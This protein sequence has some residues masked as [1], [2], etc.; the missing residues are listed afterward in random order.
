MSFDRGTFLIV[1][2][3]GTGIACGAGATS[4][5]DGFAPADDKGTPEGGTG[6]GIS[7]G[8]DAGSGHN[9]ATTRG[10][11]AGT[12]ADATSLDTPAVEKQVASLLAQMSPAQKIGQMVMV[13]Y[14][15]LASQEDITTYAL[16]ALLASGGE[17]PGNNTPQDWL[18]LTNEFRAQAASTPLQIPLI[19]GIDAVHG[20][21]K[22][23]GAT[24][25][26][27][28]IGMG[29]TRDSS[30]VTQEEQITAAEVLAMGITMSFSPDS[31]VGQDERWGRTY[32][33]F[34]ETPAL[35]SQM[36][37][38]AVGGY[39]QPSLG[40]A[41]ALLACPKHVL[42]AGGTTWGTGVDGG[43]D[44]GDTEITEAE[45]RSVH[46]PPF[47]A[48]IDAGAMA[49]MV[50]YSSWNGT[51]M[52]ASTEW[53]T[54]VIKT[55]LGFKGFLLSDYNAIGQLPG[56]RQEQE[57]TA[58]NA[59]LD[60]IMMSNPAVSPG[61][62]PPSPV[63]EGFISDIESLVPGTIPQSRIDD[64]VTRI[65]R[66]KVISG[67]FDAPTPDSSALS[68]IGSAAH[69]QVARQAVRESMVLLQNNNSVLP[70]SKSAN[71]FVAGPGADDVGVQS[72]GW[73]LGWQGV[74]NVAPTAGASSGIGGTSILAGLQSASSGVVTYSADGSGIPSSADVIVAVF[75]ENPYAEFLGDTDNPDFTN[76][77]T[78][79]DPSGNIIYDGYAGTVMS[80]LAATSIPRVL[81]LVTGRPVHLQAYLSSFDA[82]VAAWLPGS[83]GE[84][85]ADVLYG[86][87]NFVGKLPKSWPMDNTVLPISSLQTGADPLFTFGFGLA[88]P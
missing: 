51:K 64:A 57:A 83:E 17:A 23:Q 2:A 18:N 47:Q 60:M 20:A 13:D 1:L 32:E 69:R 75:Y 28:G 61:A 14:G 38:A 21:A 59:G 37:T 7:P 72:G 9:D 46:L 4:P 53:L 65:L 82:V 85:V 77:S 48:A 22:V 5:S 73:T 79:Q 30:L 49:L 45:M 16:G 56:T 8:S 26:P 15:S 41:T 63:Y 86:D 54:D 36:V 80:S 66:A 58:I 10:D 12:S 42:G 88:Y 76:T 55:E 62:P 27:H 29:A 50:S 3:A 39:Q 6:D 71:V 68:T 52:S 87:E 44:Q 34:G 24:V 81:V 19:F 33:S 67:L 25:F 74:T 40:A 31:D 84:G 70:I 78:S 43:I 35:V 11:D